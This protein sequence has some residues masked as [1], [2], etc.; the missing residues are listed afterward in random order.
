MHVDPML[1]LASGFRYPPDTDEK[2]KAMGGW[3]TAKRTPHTAVERIPSLLK[4]VEGLVGKK[5]WGIVGV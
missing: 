5:E 4:E 3:Y 2:I 1:I